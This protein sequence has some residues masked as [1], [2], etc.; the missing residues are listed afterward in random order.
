MFIFFSY[1]LLLLVYLF[2]F[3]TFRRDLVIPQTRGNAL[4]LA[5]W[6]AQSHLATVLNY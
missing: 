2:I 1:Q 5:F 3:L 6:R 4:L